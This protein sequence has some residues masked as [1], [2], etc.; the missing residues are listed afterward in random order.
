MTPRQRSLI[1]LLCIAV[2]AP[3]CRRATTPDSDA[4]SATK[5]LMVYCAAGIRLPVEAAAKRYEQEFG[6]QIKI[7]YGSSGELEGRL[8][9]DRN[10]G[11]SRCDLYIPADSSFSNRSIQKGLTRE[12]LALADFR[13]VV[14]CHPDS[15]LEASNVEQ[16]LASGVLYVVCDKKSGVGMKTWKTLEAVGKWT[17]VDARKKSS[18]PRVPEAANAIK[19]ATDVEAGFIWDTTAHQFGLK[20]LELEELQAASSHITV[21]VVTSSRQPESALRFARYLAAVDRGQEA[22]KKYG[23]TPAGTDRWSE[24]PELIVYCGGVNRNAVDKTLREFE[25]REGVVIK[26]Q[27]AGCGTLV[28]GINSIAFGDSKQRMPDAFMTC[29]ASY[30][31]KVQ[32]L[33]DEPSDVSQTQ[34][35]MLVREGNPKQLHSLKDLAKPGLAI[36]TTDPKMSTLGDLSWQLFELADVRDPIE[37]N[38]SVIV[39]TPTAHEL[40]MQMTSHRK[41]DVVLV[42][43][44][45]CKNLPGNFEL[46][47][48]EHERATAVQNIATARSTAYPS[49][50][51][52]LLQALQSETSRERFE[53]QGFQWHD[54]PMSP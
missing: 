27:Y 25:S 49:L 23:F 36:G 46:V 5:P 48:I 38:Q 47:P 33:F 22:F 52:R 20:V 29:D 35:V 9:I 40:V 8:E 44:A 34:V 17:A 3:A 43:R 41:L 30:M 39:T 16:L 10:A 7:D 45:N 28:T 51:A 42:Y 14:A 1:G 54:P 32:T 53:R 50:A 19:A 2:V 15:N 37:A 11:K 31:T 26:E 18:F 13:L 21:N 24:T 6:Q 12:S 4:A